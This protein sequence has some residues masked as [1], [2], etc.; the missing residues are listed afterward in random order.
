MNAK[1]HWRL[2]APKTWSPFWFNLVFGILFVIGLILLFAPT[3]YTRY[4]QHESTLEAAKFDRAAAAKP[5]S[6]L[7]RRVQGYNA[8]VAARQ[9]GRPLPSP[10]RTFAQVQPRGA[11]IGYVSVPAVGIENTVI[12]YGDSEKVLAQGAGTMPGTSLPYGG[13]DTLAVVTGHSG[14]ANRVI[15]DNIR[16]L[17]KGDVY[18]LTTF[19]GTRKAYRVTRL[20]VVDP[21]EKGAV[22]AVAVQ[23]GRDLAVL[24]TCTPLF[25]NSHRL[26]VYGE[27]ITLKAAAATPVIARDTF[28]LYHV[29]LY[30]MSL[31][32]LLFVAYYLWLTHKRR[33]QRRAAAGGGADQVGATAAAGDRHG[34]TEATKAADDR[35]D[36]TAATAPQAPTGD[37]PPI[38]LD[39]THHRQGRGD[40]HGETD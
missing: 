8:N 23:P 4:I 17:K 28:S 29:W 19:D 25:V 27:R 11:V 24:L 16:Y 22:E 32:V 35:R 21:R 7:V 39:Q 12:R 6:A 13:A 38:A 31:L 26:L 14:L 1:P 40:N 36:Q 3:C 18:Y 37:Q 2:F 34:Q 9:A 5:A 20:K 33:Q 15:F 10:V 30:V